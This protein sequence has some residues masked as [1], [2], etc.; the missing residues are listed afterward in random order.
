MPTPNPVTARITTV[1]VPEKSS[2][3]RLHLIAGNVHSRNL[4]VIVLMLGN[5]ITIRLVP[6]PTVYYH[7][8]IIARSVLGFL[9]VGL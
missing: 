7:V 8:L 4:G 2:N 9:E 6:V 3:V 1:Q 5:C